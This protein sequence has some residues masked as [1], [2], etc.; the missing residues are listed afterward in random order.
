MRYRINLRGF[1]ESVE[2]PDE[3][4]GIPAVAQFIAEKLGRQYARAVEA[5]N[6]EA[7]TENWADSHI[8]FIEEELE[9]LRDDAR[10]EVKA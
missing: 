2:V 10:R 7:T 5:K 3:L 8:D 6:I 1:S 9:R 4:K